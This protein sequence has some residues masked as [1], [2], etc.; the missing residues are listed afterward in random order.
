MRLGELV[1]DVMELNSLGD[2]LGSNPT[3]PPKNKGSEAV[4]SSQEIKVNY[5]GDSRSL[6]LY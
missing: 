1:T 6:N 5:L 3:V 2:L 4:L